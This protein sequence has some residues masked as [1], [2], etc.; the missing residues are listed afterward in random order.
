DRTERLGQLRNHEPDLHRRCPKRGGNQADGYRQRGGCDTDRRRQ[1]RHD[2]AVTIAS[3]G[4][5]KEGGQSG[6]L[7]LPTIANGRLTWRA[8][9]RA[10]SSRRL[11]TVNAFM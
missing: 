9:S 4:I 7:F 6:R 8:W 5:S 2:Q 3:A 10:A 11:Q 1:S